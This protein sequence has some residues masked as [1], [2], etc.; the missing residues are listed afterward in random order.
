MKTTKETNVD[1]TFLV[2]FI[3]T[4]L[5]FVIEFF[6]WGNYGEIISNFIFNILEVL[7]VKNI[8]NYLYEG[9]PTDPDNFVYFL[10]KTII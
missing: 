10:I 5:V 1:T 4:F 6:T 9:N 7:N 3:T 8:I 2:V